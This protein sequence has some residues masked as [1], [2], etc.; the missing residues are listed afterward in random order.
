[1]NIFQ[2]LRRSLTRFRKDCRGN[3]APIFAIAIIP[4]MG[5]TGAAVDYSRANAMRVSLQSALDATS[6]AMAKLSPTLTQTQLQTQTTA[7]FQAIFN[8]PDAKNITITPTY[9][10]TNG[11]QLVISATGSMDTTFMKV[12]GYSS[13]NIGSSSTVAWGNSRLRVALVLDNTGSMA[14]SNKIGALKTATN[15][16]LTQLKN[17]ATTNGDV[18]VSI[19]PFVKDV[20]AG[21][22]NYNASWVSFD[23][24]TDSSWDGANGSCSKAGNSPRSV[25]QAKSTCSV[26]G[27]N[28]QSSCTSAGTC[29]LSSYTTQST[30]TAAGTC[31]NAAE[32][33][34]SSCTSNKACSNPSYTSKN[35]CTNHSGTWG[36]GT[37]TQATW[38][39]GVWTAATWTPNNHNTWNGCVT[40]RGDAGAPNTGNYDT[41]VFAPT[42]AIPATQFAAEQY[43]SC[44]QSVMPLNYNW[45]SMTTLVNNMSPAGNTNQAIGLA[46]GWMSLVGG[47]PYPTPPAMDPNYQYSQ[48]IILLTDGLNT[49]DRWY[50][51]QS[52]ID[53]REKMTCDNINAANITLYTIQVNTGGDP[54][55]TLLQNCAGAAPSNGVPRKYPD[56]DKNFVVTNSSGIGT[57]FNQIATQ[58]SKLRI[59]K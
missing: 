36:F 35:N 1:M 55:S 40:D 22:S 52:S 53:A 17:A 2:D 8:N 46:L 43:G 25:C 56:S 28:S 51:S 27:Y 19:V 23:D 38:T 50:T 54:I 16:L 13:L 29:S 58:L 44:P 7:Y 34:Q 12:M 39:A 6:L 18:Y 41:N 37:W 21:S 24:G 31:S 14:D 49:Q 9:T 30:C 20:N 57:V 42:S 15:D 48:V 45:T 59:A 32:T 33:T 26:S 47:G 10:T 4:V 11:S 3:V 5:L